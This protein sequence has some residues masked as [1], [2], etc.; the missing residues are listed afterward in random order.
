MYYGQNIEYTHNR[1]EKDALGKTVSSNKGIF[2]VHKK[3]ISESVKKIKE[4]SLEG[5]R[6]IVLYGSCARED[7]KYRSDVDILVV[8]ED[9]SHNNLEPMRD[10]KT[11]IWHQ[12]LADIDLHFMSEEEFKNG[13]ST[14]VRAIR[15][16]GKVLWEN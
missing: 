3:T 1:K 4:S 16:D 11:N 10:L 2:D 7:A 15:K 13:H 12:G 8:L 6:Q 14:F 9:I 5:V